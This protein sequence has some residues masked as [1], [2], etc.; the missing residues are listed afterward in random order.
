MAGPWKR[1]PGNCFAGLWYKI[2]HPRALDRVFFVASPPLAAS[3]CQTPRVPFPVSL[4]DSRQM[5]LND[6]AETLGSEAGIEYVCVGRSV[7]PSRAAPAH[8]LRRAAEG[9]RP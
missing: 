2:A 9:S 5:T 4:P 8:A 6:T 3:T 7:C 1:K